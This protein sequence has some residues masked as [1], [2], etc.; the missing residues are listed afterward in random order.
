MP[1]TKRNRSASLTVRVV[2]DPAEQRRNDAIVAKFFEKAVRLHAT[3]RHAAAQ[4]AL[5]AEMRK[6]LR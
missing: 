1:N 3:R 6:I 2:T 4:A 5:N